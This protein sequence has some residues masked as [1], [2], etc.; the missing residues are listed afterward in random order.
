MRLTPLKIDR[1]GKVKITKRV[2]KNRKPKK[3]KTKPLQTFALDTI[4]IVNNGIK[5]YI[6]TMIDLNIKIAYVTSM[7]SKNTKYTALAL[8]ALLQ[9]TKI[10][11]KDKISILID[12][13]SESLQEIL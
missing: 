1:N 8:K 6:L 12:N 2:F 10:D 5:R 4:Q 7:P 13:G 3:F 11:N 9:G